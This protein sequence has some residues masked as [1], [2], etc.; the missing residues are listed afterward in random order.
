MVRK[1]DI[2]F[3]RKAFVVAFAAA[4][5]VFRVFAK[6]GFDDDVDRSDPKFV[7]ASLLVMDPGEELFSCVGHAAIRLECPTFKLDYCF[8]YE[9]ERA[10]DRLP[11]F[12]AGRLKMGMLGIKTEEFLE[13]YR[14]DGRGVRQY[15][16]NLPPAVKQRLWKHMDELAAVGPNLPYDYI[17]RGCAKSVL[18]CLKAAFAPQRVEGPVLPITQRET[19]NQELAETHPWNL[20]FLNAIVGTE[21]D[22]FAE[23]VTPKNLLSYLRRA[24]VGGVP[25]LTDEGRELL[26]RVLRSE[27]SPVSP[28]VVAWLVFALAAVAAVAN[29]RRVHWAF[30]AVQAAAGCFF[31]YLV[32]ASHLPN[33]AWNWLLVPFNPLMPVL[34]FWRRMRAVQGVLR[35]YAGALGCWIGLMLFV[36]H[37]KTD[38][39]FIV[40]AGALAVVYAGLVG[41][42]RWL[43]IMHRR[44]NS[45]AV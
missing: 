3:A 42:G 11:A 33:S 22:T 35:F 43:K 38:P 18:D 30:L 23:V 2:W 45:A 40:L 5:C 39:A 34:V 10:V 32:S 25:L 14:R 19:F 27:K 20:F 21:T 28:F 31:V 13:D 24:R 29:W 26:P 17:K 44:N 9:S 41:D 7:T 6:D 1:F 36:P 15:V 4:L 12:F 8:S 16:L 37:A